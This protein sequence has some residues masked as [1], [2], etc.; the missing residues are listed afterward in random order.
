MML[1][2]L[3]CDTIYKMV[4]EEKN[5]NFKQNKLQVDL[6]KLKKAQSMAQFFACFVDLQRDK[7]PLERALDMIDK[8]YEKIG[9]NIGN[10]DIARNY[11]EIINNNNEGKI[12]GV[13]TIEG[14]EALKG[15]ISNLRNFYKLG[16]RLV[17][18]TWNYQNEIGYPGCVSEFKNKGL[19]EF[20]KELVCEMNRL[21]MIVDVSHLSDAGFYDVI[22]YSSKPIM[23]SHSNSR[24]IQNHSRNLTDDM[25]KALAENG[26]V[27]G[28]NF[29]N[30]FLS[31]KKIGSVGDMAK[32]IKHIV[33]VGGIDIM[34]V[35]TDFD[36]INNPPEIEDIGGIYK[37][38]E[39]LRKQGF[40]EEDIDKIF[41]KNALRV[42]KEVL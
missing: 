31:S 34:A 22:K 35:G 18:L 19:T 24:E 29:C 23:A 28:L 13:L 20:G 6:N 21:G 2:D 38:Y 17:T 11:D 36:G 15:K 42:I 1:I 5:I 9:E 10:I 27:M 4:E 12:S 39:E 3:H 16:V 41:Y 32:H 7:N 14:G 26:G 25:I 40:S 33:N 8:F 30:A 37:L